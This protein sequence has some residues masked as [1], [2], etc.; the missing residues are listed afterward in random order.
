MTVYL[1]R[2][3]KAGDRSAWTGDDRFRPLTP[4]GWEQAEALAER[5]APSGPSRLLSSPYV[6]C[7][8]TLDP[9]ARRW[10][11]EVEETSMLSEGAAFE[12]VLELLVMLPDHTVL[13]SHG[14]LIPDVIGA[15]IRRGAVLVGE[16]N[17]KK[18]SAWLLT[19]TETG[20]SRVAASPP[21]GAP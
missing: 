17:W 9:L 13:C 20:V 7:T 19:R 16:P 8:Q 21:P 11:T 3:A 1:V 10:D 14:D 2:H 5:F 6:R 12:P 15:L 18:A 4:K